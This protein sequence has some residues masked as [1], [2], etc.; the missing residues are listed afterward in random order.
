[1]L[2]IR[3]GR[4]TELID[5]TGLVADSISISSG[6]VVVY[7]PHTTTGIF[8]N[9]KDPALL[10]D[11]EKALGKL[12]PQGASYAHD[13]GEGNADSHIKGILMGN[14]VVV[15]VEDGKMVLGTWQSIIFAELDGPR[16]RKVIVKEVQG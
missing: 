12:V 9:E 16:S 3:S 2:N 11:I 8:V 6:L 1:M 10:V 4:R 14:S 7:T 13:P 5:I 15:P